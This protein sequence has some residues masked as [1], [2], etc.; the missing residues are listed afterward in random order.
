MTEEK[1][2]LLIEIKRKA[3]HLPALIIPFG[4]LY[5]PAW[6][7][8]PT[9]FSVAML[10]L[11]VE[12]LRLNFSPV[13]KLFY[14]FFGP[15]LREHERTRITGSTALILSAT[16][17]TLFFV[18]FSP[19]IAISPIGKLSMF[20]SFSFLILGDALAAVVGKRVGGPK[21]AGGKT[22]AGSLACFFSCLT[23]YFVCRGAGIA[24]ID[25][26]SALAAMILTTVL[27]AVPIR[28][29]DN[30]RVAPAVC[31]LLWVMN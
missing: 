10:V 8:V 23:I 5:F 17:C 31:A 14:R 6:F 15:L 16:L 18:S 11:T 3:I 12:I 27:E 28:L 30:L 20:Y 13:Q 21:L 29:D 4:L 25:F 9:L 26:T 2:G 24:E 1:T 7:S 22:I 19:E